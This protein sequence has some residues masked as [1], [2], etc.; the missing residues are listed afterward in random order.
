MYY[1]I[2]DYQL[3]LE[4]RKLCQNGYV[5]SDDPKIIKLLESLCSSY[6]DVFDKQPL[7]EAI[8]PDQVVTDWS[9][10]RLV[11]DTRQLL[12]DSGKDQD[13]IKTNRSRGYRLNIKIEKSAGEV[14]LNTKTKKTGRQLIKTKSLALIVLVISLLIFF[15]YQYDNVETQPKL[16][17]RIAVL[18]VVS[19]TSAPIDEWIK[20]GIMSMVSEQ[21]GRYKALQTLPVGTVISTISGMDKEISTRS[22]KFDVL[23]NRLGCSHLVILKYA[24]DKNNQPLLSYQ[25]LSQD[26]SSPVSIFSQPDVILATEMM[27]DNLAKDLI[28]GESE[29]ISLNDTYSDDPKANRDYAIGVHE[30]IRGDFSSAKSYLLLA[31]NRKP[32]FFWANAYLAEV[33]YRTSNVQAA[34]NLI[35]QL[36]AASL[37]GQQ[38]YFLE[39]L[40]SD[41]L[42]TLGKLEESLQVSIK[43]LENN[44]VRTHP[45]LMGKEMRNIG[46]SYQALGRLQLAL[47][48]HQQALKQFQLAKFEPGRAKVFYNMGNVF[49]YSGEKQKAIDYYHKAKEIFMKFNMNGYALMARHMIA[50]TSTSLGKIQFAEREL[51]SLIEDYRKI[52]N[53]QGEFNALSDLVGVSMAKEDYSEAD[54]RIDSL[55]QRLESTELSSLKSHV[56]AQAVRCNLELKNLIKAEAYFNQI[57]SEWNDIRPAFILLS[58]HIMHDK[59]ELKQAVEKANKIKLSLGSDWTLEH[60]KILQQF[61]ASLSAGQIYKVSY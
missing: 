4:T 56:M 58:A 47:D 42:Y 17:F 20:Y 45:L 10:T 39:H 15:L 54:L 19:E 27:L 26:Y 33:E 32:E 31:I 57:D 14:G 52:G 3:D 41:I 34:I 30:L 2:G 22:D 60:Q 37:T 44:Y 36:K 50:S 8:W 35:K 9:L 55:L 61:E 46:S 28:P 23:C 49:L 1:K 21:L 59:G 53:L 18:P 11:S 7:K 25:I 40:H 16:P 24:L 48:F 43:L 12:G 38:A 13:Y 51:R 6:P 5:V 29:R